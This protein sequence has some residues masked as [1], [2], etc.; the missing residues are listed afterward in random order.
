M[1]CYCVEP[2]KKIKLTDW[3]PQEKDFCPEGKD[4]GVRRLESLKQKLYDLQVP[5]FAENQRKLLVVLQGM[6][7][8]GKDGT[9]RNVFGGLDPQGIKVATFGKPSTRELK[10]DYLWRIHRQTP[11]KGQIGIFNRSH[12]EDVLAVRVRN[13]M[14]KSVWSKRF[15]HINDF[16]RMMTDEGTTIIKIFLHISFEEQ[17]ERLLSRKNTPRKQWKL[18]PQ[19]VEDRKLWPAYTEAYEDTLSRTSTK[20]APWWVVPADRK[21]YRNLLVASLV[22]DALQKLNPQYPEPA[23]DIAA[24]EI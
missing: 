16:E 3:D 20:D 6:D 22:C 11:A 21:W 17:R 10:H 12:Y 9:I 15:D 23:Y 24:I 1:D 19:D 18:I 2:G 7:T 4:E 13:L 14:P 8:A 5:F